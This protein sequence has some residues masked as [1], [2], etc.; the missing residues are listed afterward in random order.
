MHNHKH[1]ACAFKILHNWEIL[2]CFLEIFSSKQ[3]PPLFVLDW[4]TCLHYKVFCTTRTS[5]L[6]G[7]WLHICFFLLRACI[8][9][10]LLLYLLCAGAED[11]RSGNLKLILGMIWTLIRKYQIGSTGKTLPKKLMLEW[12]NAVLHPHLTVT[13]FSTDWND[14]RALQWVS[15]A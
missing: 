8:I 7:V 9:T 1:Y 13:N 14:G 5:I 2:F 10:W 4:L 3:V 6:W 11:I 12:I 15:R